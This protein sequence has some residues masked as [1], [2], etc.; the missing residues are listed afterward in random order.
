MARHHHKTGSI[1]RQVRRRQAKAKARLRKRRQRQAWKTVEGGR[2]SNKIRPTPQAGGYLVRQFWEHLGLTEALEKLGI[3]KFKGLAVSTLLLV[4]LLF[5]V[6]GARSVSDLAD[7]ASADPVLLECCAV[8]L[9]ERKQLYRLL[10]KLTKDQYQA[11]MQ[12]ILRRLQADP[13]TASRPDGVVAGDETTMFKWGDKMPAVTWVFKS[14]EQRFGLGYEVVSTC[15]ADRDKFYTLFCDFRLPTEAQRQAQA[16]KRKRKKMGLDQRKP[17]DVIRWLQRQVEDGEAPEWVVLSGP[18]LSQIL[19]QACERLSLP[20]LGLSDRRRV[21]HLGQ[22]NKMRKVKAGQ[23]LDADY[24]GRWQQ[25]TDA[26]YRVVLVG[27]ARANKIGQV[28]L[29]V[30]ECLADGGRL[31]IVTRS[32]DEVRLLQ[33]VQRLLERRAEADNTKLHRMIELFRQGREAGIRAETATFDSWFYVVWFIQEVLALGFRRVVTKTRSNIHYLYQGEKL[34]IEQL[35]SKVRRYRRAPGGDPQVK[36]SSLRVTQ[37]GLGRI[38]LVFVRE[39]N[40]RSKLT[41]E[42]VLMCTDPRYANSKVHRAYK[43]RWRIEEIYRETRQNHGLEEF[44][45]RNINAIY[46]HVF[47]SF[48]SH[49]CLV[50]TRLLSSKL[51]EMTLGQIMCKVFRALVELVSTVEGV[52]VRF[53]DEFLERYGLP[54]F[55]T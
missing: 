28:V 33:R 11:W 32:D 47:L 48:L 40:R 17:A 1:S 37:P 41:H 55:C 6:L 20:W 34:T 12:H 16:Q 52:V 18:H 51:K 35:Q 2:T 9:L 46:G 23:I 7:K 15:Y 21:Y 14:S 53:S 29:L 38:K 30:A 22:G 39:Y 43:L 5:G 50:A 36:F 8:E 31:L 13:R 3:R 26:G 10:G 19:T 27:S 25:L 42:Y 24:K 49:T 54:D 45:C 44:H 4:A